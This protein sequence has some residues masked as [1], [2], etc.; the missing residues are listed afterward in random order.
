MSFIEFGSLKVKVQSFLGDVS[1]LK[2][3]KLNTSYAIKF[4]K[5]SGKK[6]FANDHQK[7]FLIYEESW[8]SIQSSIVVYSLII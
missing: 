7:T 3:F 8:Q 2:A 6:V 5:C 4:Y 1:V